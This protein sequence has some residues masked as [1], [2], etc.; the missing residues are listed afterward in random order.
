MSTS[1]LPRVVLHA[2]LVCIL[3]GYLHFALCVNCHALCAVRGSP[4][5]AGV[6]FVLCQDLGGNAACGTLRVADVNESIVL[7]GQ[8]ACT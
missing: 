6:P 4:R 7:A 3:I 1:C 8:A 5:A 2:R